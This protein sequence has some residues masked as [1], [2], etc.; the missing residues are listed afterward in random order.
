LVARILPI[1]Y[2]AYMHLIARTGRIVRIGVEE[3]FEAR[4]RGTS[5]VLAVLH[6]DL[7]LGP[8]LFRDQGIVTLANVGDAGEII[9]A[10]LE[11]CGCEVVRGGSSRRSSRRTPA[12]ADMIARLSAGGREGAVIAAVTPD[13]SWGPAGAVKPGLVSIAMG[14]A[15]EI[16][17]LKIH[18]SRALYAPTWDRTAIPLPFATVH[19]EIDGPIRAPAAGATRSEVEET[20]VEVERRL[21]ALHARAFARWS[22]EPIPRLTPLGGEAAAEV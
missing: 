2:L 5:V 4:R 17:C 8:Y 22:R 6:Q 3:M 20:R 15:A 18:A 16:Y 9:T 11:R 21:H 1:L 14:T 19:V 7:F 10:L 13:G 12:V